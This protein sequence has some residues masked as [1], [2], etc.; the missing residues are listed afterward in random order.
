MSP[1][2]IHFKARP[3]GYHWGYKLDLGRHKTG[4]L[5]RE[6]RRRKGDWSVRLERIGFV[7]SHLAFL[8]LL[9]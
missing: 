3:R 4:R 8:I 9:S 5:F 7:P 2:L 1:N 6:K